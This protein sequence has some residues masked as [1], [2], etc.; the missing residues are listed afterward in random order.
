V[1]APST[2]A[3]AP[4]V[5]RARELAA[6]C[7]RLARAAQG[8]G[9]TVLVGGEPGIGKTRLV[10]ELASHAA[11]EGWRVLWGRTYES[12][13]MPPYLP[14]AEAL[15]DYVRT[16]PQ[17]AL[18]AQLGDSGAEVAL[19]VREVHGRV[20]DLP[21]P[22]SL[23]PEQERYRLFESVCDF[24]Q[25]IA[26]DAAPGL[27][28]VLDDLHWADK[29]TLLL[30]QHLARRLAVTRLVVVGTYRTVDLA[31]SHP[32]SEVLADLSRERL[33]ER[34]S[35]GAVARDDVATLV[36]ALA[37]APAAPVLIDAIVRETEGNPFFVEEI[38]RQ[39]QAEGRQ[40][41]DPRA[42]VERWALP[43]SV[44]QVVGRRLARLGTDANR[45]L[46]AAAV[47]G[48]GFGFDV[49]GAVCGLDF[50]ALED[51]LDE[52]LAAGM[53]REE[54]GRHGF[55]HALIW[56]TLYAELNGPR[57]MRLHRA[58]AE[59]L[60]RAYAGNAE[61]HL[62]ELA[63]HF[64]EAGPLGDPSRAVGYARRSGERAFGLLAY[65]EGARLFGLA[66]QATELQEAPDPLQRC[67]LLLALGAAQRMAGELHASLES[68]RD[69]AAVARRVGAGET[70]ARAALGFEDAML[71]TGMPR[72]PNGDPSAALLEEGLQALADGEGALRARLLGGLARAVYFAGDR[73]RGR[74]VAENAVAMARRNGDPAA[75]AYAMAAKRIAISGPDG[76]D[77]R[78]HV[79]TE[80]K[81]LAR[82]AGDY[83]L[84][85]EGSYWRARTLLELG[86]VAGADAE[87]DAYTRIVTQLRQPRYLSDAEAFRLIRAMLEGRFEDAERFA[88]STL[89]FAG[90]ASDQTAPPFV[91]AQTL[92]LRIARGTDADLA[93]IEPAVV[94][95]VESVGLPRWRAMLALL[96]AELGREEDARHQFE[97]VALNDFADV[98]RE[99]LWRLAMTCMAEV[100]VYLRDLRRAEPLYQL[101]LPHA[102]YFVTEVGSVGS[103]AR[104][105]GMLAALLGRWDAAE[106]H[107]CA[108]IEANA[109]VGARP[110]LARSRHAYAELLRARRGRGDGARAREQL[111]AASALYE[112]LAMPR[113]QG[114]VQQLLREPPAAGT[115]PAYPAGLSEREVEVLRLIATGRSNQ[116]IA[117]TL[118]LSVRTVERHI[119]NIY[120][121]IDARGK[122]D[123]TTFAL[124]HGLVAQ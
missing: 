97:L 72:D 88:R 62:A 21:V 70:L 41:G 38:V 109:R 45:M 111:L 60:E 99:W 74:A 116:E 108:A 52:A 10:A 44:R 29:P 26:R 83:P 27:L 119:T 93:A 89:D 114:R 54:G 23:G 66:L 9:G 22:P 120:A 95:H 75:L 121:K 100:C 3:G 103:V 42:A 87:I 32:L 25:S 12:E 122:A 69:C 117:D 65:E 24:L 68:Y 4:F 8:H 34:I 39:L 96:Y 1:S 80:L 48:E 40:L 81:Q 35:L 113:W 16:C 20:P 13:G 47:L 123:A 94:H 90:R 86:D 55:T 76:I 53:L 78:L 107:L 92:F 124:R 31:R 118:V 14:F 112:A 33:Y 104:H 49:L 61:P 77:E 18:Q 58:A 115:A 91:L 6:L 64:C 11:V 106:A 17:A 57:R 73:Q 63:Y 79:A 102:T 30:L 36:D 82:T 67:E 98:P 2:P 7:E 15:R 43:E 84:L 101:L 85:L 56:Q 28:L 46:Q 59:A 71:L 51:A 19:I 50:A 5:G 37:G 110:A 105:L